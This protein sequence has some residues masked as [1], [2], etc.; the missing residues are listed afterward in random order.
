M[1]LRD[2]F[3]EEL[4]KR[5]IDRVYT[6]LKLES[7]DPIQQ[8]AVHLANGKANLC[9]P[10]NGVVSYDVTGR[11]INL[12]PQAFLGKCN[13]T[14]PILT[15]EEFLRNEKLQQFPYILVDCEFYDM[16]SNKEKSR[17]KVQLKATLGVVR[18]YMWDGRMVIVGRRFDEVPCLYYS[19]IKEFVDDRCVERIILLDPSADK[20]FHG[21]KADCYVIGGIVDKSGDKKGLTSKI[22]EKMREEGVEFESMRIELRGDVVGVPDRLNS[23]TE[24]VLMNVL[25]GYDLE[26]AIKRTQSKITAKWRLRKEIHKIAV[27]VDRGNKVFRIVKKSDY[28]KFDWLNLSFGDFVDVCRQMGFL[29][30]E[31]E[32]YDEVRKLPY[33][34][35][36]DRYLF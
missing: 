35:R 20:V 26:T 14:Q 23:I 19:S 1:R 34:E 10:E 36:K 9:E 33:D 3:I 17:L 22:G 12:P 29:I 28:A 6:N 21:E 5:G 16:H 7:R 25:E 13:L 8:M 24:L 30:V 15:S 18:D 32:I 2:I 4:R 27:R 31:D 11:R